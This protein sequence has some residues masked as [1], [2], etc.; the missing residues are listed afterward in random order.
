MPTK[1]NKRVSNE[2]LLALLQNISERLDRL[3]D[4]SILSEHS[5]MRDHK[6]F[7]ENGDKLLTMVSNLVGSMDNVENE[8]VVINHHNSEHFDK[9]E[10]QDTRLDR[11]ENHFQLPKLAL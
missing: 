6:R 1:P 2:D 5:N 3:D 8:L 4:R 9:N 10:Q 11:I 7:K